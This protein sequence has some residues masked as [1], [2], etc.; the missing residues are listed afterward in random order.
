[1]EHW[2][3]AHTKDFTPKLIQRLLPPFENAALNK[4]KPS[5][6][7]V[8]GGATGLTQEEH[9]AISDIFRLDLMESG[10]YEF[11]T[12]PDALVR[13]SHHKGLKPYQVSITAD[14]RLGRLSA[15]NLQPKTRDMYL[16]ADP[17]DIE[18]VSFVA[19]C[20]ACG[21]PIVLKREAEVEIAFF[22]DALEA[23]DD[24]PKN[25][26][27]LCGWFDLQHDYMFFLSKDMFDAV[28]ER[29]KIKGDVETL[30]K[31]HV[32]LV[33]KPKNKSDPH[34]SMG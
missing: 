31:I 34:L 22:E 33:E 18:R 17:R 3:S 10:W 4:G 12:I 32:E 24:A 5:V 25:F 16:I 8:F 29:F 15:Y 26:N 1:M 21:G 30:T 28:R 6:D 13:F 7:M 20:L 19:A 14:P 23:I 9:D 27:K 2:P 11:R